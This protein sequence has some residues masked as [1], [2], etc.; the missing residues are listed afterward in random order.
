[1]IPC[2]PS[3]SWATVCTRGPASPTAPW[4]SVSWSHPARTGR[5]SWRRVL[6][7]SCPPLPPR[8]R[9]WPPTPSR[10]TEAACWQPSCRRTTPWP[11]RPT[12]TGTPFSIGGTTSVHVLRRSQSCAPCPT[13]PCSSG[14]G[15]RWRQAGRSDASCVSTSPGGPSS[16]RSPSSQPVMFT[17]WRVWQLGKAKPIASCSTHPLV[18]CLLSAPLLSEQSCFSDFGKH[19]AKRC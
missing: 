7:P 17:L 13:Q 12:G 4:R 19:G 9:Q 11:R 5:L 14:T 10:S 8:W 2:A 18:H 6:R 3:S 16:S 1:M 15:R